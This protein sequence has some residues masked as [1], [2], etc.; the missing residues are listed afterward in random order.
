MIPLVTK[1]WFLSVSNVYLFCNLQ[2]E[3]YP[4]IVTTQSILET[5]YYTCNNCSLR[6]NNI[7]GFHNGKRY[8]TF[9]NWQ[10]SVTYYAKW[11]KKHYKGGDYYKFL[12]DYGYASDTNYINKLKQIH[13]SNFKI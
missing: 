11:Q 13:G 7:F 4:D 9:D 5:G 8:L 12:K 3:N 1:I 2:I 6:Y 10:E